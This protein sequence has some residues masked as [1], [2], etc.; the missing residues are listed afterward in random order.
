M[1]RPDSRKKLRFTIRSSSEWNEMIANRPPLTSGKIAAGMKR[2]SPLS[3]SLT[4]IRSAWNVRVA[5]WM[6]QRPG[7][8]SARTTTSASCLVVE[9][10]TRSR[11]RAIARA[12]LRAP[13]SSP[14]SKIRSASSGSESWFTRSAAVTPLLWSIR[15]SSGAS[16]EKLNPRSIRPSCSDDTPRSASTPRTSVTPTRSSTEAML[17]KFAWT[18]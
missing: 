5:G 17:S 1:H 10:G 11:I 6:R 9:M 3:S 12:I 15:I 4:A 13:R 2:S 7:M 14:N 8:L 16:D 18:S